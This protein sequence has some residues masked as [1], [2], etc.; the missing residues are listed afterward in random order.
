MIKRKII[1]SRYVISIDNRYQ[2][3]KNLNKR[4]FP[5]IELICYNSM[6]CE[7]VSWHTYIFTK[8]G[9]LSIFCVFMQLKVIPSLTMIMVYMSIKAR[10]WKSTRKSSCGT[11]M[12]IRPNLQF[13]L[14]WKSW[15]GRWPQIPK[16]IFLQNLSVH[17]IINT[18]IITV[19]VLVHNAVQ[20][21]MG[22]YLKD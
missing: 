18:W 14:V 22:R 8:L 12:I 15:L 5:N 13:C 11:M 16:C 21:I 4:I 2:L 9:K 7:I 10:T 3:Y 1:V 20:F 19:C 17:S 6:N